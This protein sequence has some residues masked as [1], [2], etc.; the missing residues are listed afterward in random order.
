MHP[1]QIVSMAL[2]RY[3]IFLGFHLK[4]KHLEIVHG[5]DTAR[6][7]L[8]WKKKRKMSRVKNDTASKTKG[9]NWMVNRRRTCN[10]VPTL[11]R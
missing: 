1:K 6:I 2:S 4:Y 9:M 3:T 5:L 8:E 7:F 10:T 11:I